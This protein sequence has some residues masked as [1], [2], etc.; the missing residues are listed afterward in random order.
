VDEPT[1]LQMLIERDL[2]EKKLGTLDDLVAAR[3]TACV[4]WRSIAAELSDMTSRDVT[5][6][7]V[8]RW[9]AD[10]LQIEVTVS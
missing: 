5:G 2:A 9:F 7:A 8:R 6:E 4:S 3:R 10:R 1:K